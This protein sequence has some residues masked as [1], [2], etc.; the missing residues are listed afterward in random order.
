MKI[1][2]IGTS[3]SGKTYIAEKLS[4]R[5]NLLHLDLDEIFWDN[6]T[7]EYNIKR[8][9]DERNSL[10]ST[11]LEKENWVIEGVYYDWLSQSF[12]EADQIFIFQTPARIFNYRVIKRFIKRKL[13]LEN[14]KTGSLKSTIKM[15]KWANRYQ[16]RNMPEIMKFLEPYSD[17]VVIAKSS[18]TIIKQLE[19]SNL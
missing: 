16:K 11:V 12:A 2:I 14:G 13:K 17:K 6:S 3:G 7:G 10:L 9:A 5:F 18:T 8:L 4:Q 15:I 19:K 1:H